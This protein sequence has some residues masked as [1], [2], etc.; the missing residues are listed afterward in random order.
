[1]AGAILP[2]TEDVAGAKAADRGRP[3]PSGCA[4]RSP[5]PVRR[6]SGFADVLSGSV[7]QGLQ[8]AL[9]GDAGAF[10][11]DPRRG[12]AVK[13]GDPV[14]PPAAARFAGTGDELLE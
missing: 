6:G 11:R 5:F 10:G 2:G 3:P 4:G 1:M 9:A 12:L 14:S 8:L 13:P 7:G